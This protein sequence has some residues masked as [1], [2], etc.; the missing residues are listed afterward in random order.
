MWKFNRDYVRDLGGTSFCRSRPIWV[1]Y[2]QVGGVAMRL[3][4][5]V[6]DKVLPRFGL[7]ERQALDLV[8]H[9]EASYP[10]RT[11]PGQRRVASGKYCFIVAD[12]GET[13]ITVFLDKVVTP[14]RP[15]QIAAGVEIKR[16]IEE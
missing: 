9:P 14:L 3:T 7:T 15:D 1:W 4:R 6:R 11:Y 2:N 13:V 8:E 12:D 5:H 16:K 10:S